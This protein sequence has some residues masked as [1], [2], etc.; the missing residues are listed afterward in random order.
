MRKKRKGKKIS[1]HPRHL[2]TLTIKLTKISKH[3]DSSNG[4]R[5]N[6]AQSGWD[7]FW[8]LFIYI[9][10]RYAALNKI[11]IVETNRK[12]FIN[13]DFYATSH[14]F[15]HGSSFDAQKSLHFDTEASNNNGEHLLIYCYIKTYSIL[16]T[17]FDH[18]M[19]HHIT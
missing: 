2:S 5:T 15:E 4:K 6:Q 14:N 9:K 19:S 3:K 12:H 18:P 13:G 1:S 16:D 11:C 8:L 17:L 10:K 7:D